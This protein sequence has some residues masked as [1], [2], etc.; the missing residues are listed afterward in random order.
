[1]KRKFKVLL[2]CVSVLAV[3]LVITAIL[4]LPI[5][6]D[7]RA[8]YAIDINNPRQFAGWADYVFVGKVEKNNGLID[9]GEGSR[10]L[11]T[12]YQV[13]VLENLKGTLLMDGP[14][15]VVKCGGVY[16]G[17]YR[18]VMEDDVLPDTGKTYVFLATA[19]T[20]GTLLVYGANSNIALDDK[21]E[22][23]ADSAVV[24]NYRDAVKNQIDTRPTK[25]SVAN[26]DARAVK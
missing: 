19:S 21:Q 22:N 12:E 14:I 25:R 24:R 2:A 20:D 1:M 6:A 13:Q 5:S 4:V 10:E 9:Q 17:I 7:I 15:S 8:D 18:E 26:A 23:I 11:F 16:G 3:G